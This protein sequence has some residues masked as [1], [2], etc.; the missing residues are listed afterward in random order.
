[1]QFDSEVIGLADLIDSHLHT[2][3]SH[4]EHSMRAKYRN[5]ICVD[6]QQRAHEAN[7]I[8]HDMQATLNEPPM[9]RVLPAVEFKSSIPERR[10]DFEK[11]TGNQFCKRDIEP[12]LKTLSDE[13]THFIVGSK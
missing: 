1:V 7:A 2:H 8:L 3:A 10:N 11:N 9:T 13:Y 12:K 4:S 6:S 5:A